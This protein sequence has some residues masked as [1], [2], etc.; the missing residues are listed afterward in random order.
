MLGQT[1]SHYRILE[2]LGGGGMG[3]VYKAED[4]KLRRFVAL[5]FL[6]EALAE[7]RQALERI[8]R[9]AQAA[10]ALSH[11]N[12]CTI[13]DI[14]EFEGQRFIA[15]ELLEGQT[16]RHCIGSKPL[17]TDQLLDLA[18]QMADG[19]DAA[20]SKGIIHRDIKPANIF[21]TSRGQAK[22]LDFGLAKLSSGA[23][24]SA[25]GEAFHSSQEAK[26]GRDARARQDTP[27]LS[28]D[29]KHLTSPG[30]AM[31]TV[32]YMSPE[33]ARGEELDVRTDLFSFGAV[34]YE[35]ATG[36]PAFDGATSAVIFHQ[37]LAQA[38]APPLQLNPSLPPRLE[39][40]INKALEKDRDLRCH[41]A[42]DLRADLK[43]LKRD[44]DSGRS[45]GLRSAA[46][47]PRP[48]G[49]PAAV[50]GAS[51]SGAGEEHGQDARA[52]AGETRA[53]RRWLAV[54]AGIVVAVAAI[55][56][57]FWTRPVPV[58]KISNYVQLTHD[59]R[60]K[61]L[62][63]TDGSRLYFGVGG[64]TREGIAQ[65]SVTG[66][67]PVRIHTP[68]E[69]MVPL[70]VSPDGSDLLVSDQLGTLFTGP[71]WSLPV[72]GGSPRLLADTVGNG[73]AWSPD[74]HTLAYTNGSDLFL[75]KSDGTESHELVSV[76]GL[77]FAPVWSVDG[78]ELRLT[79]QDLKTSGQ[80]LWEVS[81][82]GTNLHPLLAGWHNPPD[83]CC[84]MWTADGRYFV[85]QSQGQIWAL[86]EKGGLLRKPSGTPVQ[87][88][89]S[90]LSLSTPLPGKDGKK[91]FVVGQTFHGGLVRYD[92]KASQ[93]VPFLSGISAGDV[94]FSKDGQWVA[95]VTYPGG[96]LW[97]SKADG[98]EPVQLSYPPLHAVLP[99]WSPDGK[100]IVYYSSTPGK[101]ERIY[102]VS[103]EGGSAYPLLP[104]DPK[105][106]LDPNWSPDGG[107]IVFSGAA[108]HADSTIRVLD[109]SNHQVSTLPGSQGLF[110][111][112][113]SPDGRNILAMPINSLSLVLFDFH[114]EKWAEVLKGVSGFPN[115]SRDGRYVYFLYR[116][117]NAAVLRVRISD[118]KVERV[119]DLRNLPITGHYGLWLGLAPDDSPMLLRDTGTQDI[120][121]L[122]WQAP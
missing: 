93:F 29:P 35:M 45:A 43:R 3:V 109:L 74:G 96:D 79:V 99:R 97:R 100:Q 44:T 23:A 50:A 83:E 82:Q 49:V 24:V 6:P 18:I 87:L 67:E 17:K 42:G 5:K 2:K 69:S 12:I 64:A 11:P 103:V 25:V 122:D 120:Y 56:A 117:D 53:P 4:T 54:G 21:I 34:L 115:W 84:G 108:A 13:Y 59:G 94:A 70:S 55:L 119:A 22:I 32:A 40:I 78:R 28:I 61:E 77:A 19:L 38:P 114:T 10:S 80:S 86:P 107:K 66:G 76:A 36:R 116:P 20:H 91:L 27:T 121:A 73:G 98:S 106:Q 104:D 58:P 9:E 30:V 37:I 1:V 33:Q 62:V 60:P 105:P 101:P 14:D 26:H 92:S 71:L 113:W 111:P 48:V 112:R 15:M 8:Q 16:L 31:G 89:S 41:S 63:G 72:L 102:A 85:F 39:E 118:R 95:Y 7:D 88:T 75:A 68:S 57:Y 47:L 110:S 65:E 51:R 81:A 90:P 46:S 52:T